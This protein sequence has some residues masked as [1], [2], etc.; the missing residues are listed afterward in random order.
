[1]FALAAVTSNLTACDKQEGPRWRNINKCLHFFFL[2][3]H[4]KHRLPLETL[5]TRVSMAS[6]WLAWLLELKGAALRLGL[7]PWK[8]IRYKVRSSF[9]SR[10]PR[11]WHRRGDRENTDSK[12]LNATKKKQTDNNS[13]LRCLQELRRYSLTDWLFT[14]FTAWALRL[15]FLM[16][17]LC[18]GPRLITSSSSSPAQFLFMLFCSA[19]VF[20]SFM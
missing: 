4:L 2:N 15:Q 5:V 8:H 6:K 16:V 3:T 20:V 7:A 11:R 9:N 1:M 18:D 19:F 10:L 12:Y 14:F 17:H 13:S